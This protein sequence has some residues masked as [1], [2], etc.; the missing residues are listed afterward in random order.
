MPRRDDTKPLLS[1]QKREAAKKVA[2]Q[3]KKDKQKK[4]TRKV[5]KKA[6]K[7]E[8]K[9]VKK[10]ASKLPGH[11]SKFLSRANQTSAIDHEVY[12]DGITKAVQKHKRGDTKVKPVT[13]LMF[14][15]QGGTKFDS[16][17]A[18]PGQKFKTSTGKTVV[19]R[20]VGNTFRAHHHS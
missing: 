1:D 6:V 20:D 2:E 14:Q 9:E 12:R 10:D 7:K 16:S 18:V 5:V 19:T 11:G 8:A 17:H 3:K 4:E 15:R 13:S